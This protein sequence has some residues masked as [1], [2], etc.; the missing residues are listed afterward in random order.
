MNNKR[1][2][3]IVVLLFLVVMTMG[4]AL[5]SE[6]VTIGGTATGKGNLSVIINDINE[7]NI[8]KIGSKVNK[9]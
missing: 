6:T 4:Y 1:K 5:F 9:I 2:S 7:V 8:Y 3:I